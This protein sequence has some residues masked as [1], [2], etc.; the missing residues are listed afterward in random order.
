MAMSIRTFVSAP[1][2]DLDQPASHT[3]TLHVK[4]MKVK[5]RIGKAGF[6]EDELVSV[7]IATALGTKKRVELF[8]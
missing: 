8:R 4:C 1:H 6:P 7:G 2:F 5:C 3:Y